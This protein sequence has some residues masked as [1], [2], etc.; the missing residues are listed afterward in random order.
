[1]RKSAPGA[2]LL[3]GI[4]VFGGLFL[5]SPAQA[6]DDDYSSSDL[7]LAPEIR[8]SKT[9][10]KYHSKRVELERKYGK[11]GRL[12]LPPLVIRP[13]RDTD[14]DFL[15]SD[16]S[17]KSSSAG[18]I[19]VN[20]AAKDLESQLRTSTLVDPTENT[21]IDITKVRITK[22]TPADV[23]IQAAQVGLSAMAA[24]A[25]FLSLL[26]VSRAIRRK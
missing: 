25:L 19:A 9:L 23:F 22:R 17:V 8:E 2:F 10:S 15:N 1:M 13:T 14:D 20:P 3:T 4:L 26:A 16:A 12:L 7:D 24:G 21:A 18:F 11:E 5:A 6:E